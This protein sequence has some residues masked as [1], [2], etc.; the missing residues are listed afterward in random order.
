MSHV[1]APR[2][3]FNLLSRV[4]GQL[5]GLRSGVL[6]QR[7]GEGDLGQYTGNL[8]GLVELNVCS[9]GE[10][11]NNSTLQYTPEGGNGMR[12]RFPFV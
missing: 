12:L 8:G 9:K 6:S 1:S 7:E 4:D 3:Q 10:K 11:H 5:H 2:K